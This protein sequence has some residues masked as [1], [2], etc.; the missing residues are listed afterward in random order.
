MIE[1]NKIWNIVW[2]QYDDME[3][4][5][6]LREVIM[7]LSDYLN[8]MEDTPAKQYVSKDDLEDESRNLHSTLK[9]DIDDSKHELTQAIDN[10]QQTLDKLQGADPD[11]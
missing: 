11:V 6:R 2:N 8:K 1:T 4:V 7:E 3:K 9:A 10:I 5:E